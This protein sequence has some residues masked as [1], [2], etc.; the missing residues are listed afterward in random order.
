MNHHKSFLVVD[1][2]KKPQQLVQKRE[3]EML[4]AG[5]RLYVERQKPQPKL[6]PAPVED[7]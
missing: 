2:G 5:F 1:G 6:P 7:E 3:V 4:C